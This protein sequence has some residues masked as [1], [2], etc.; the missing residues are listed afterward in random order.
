LAV[1]IGG[2]LIGL[3]AALLL[4][5]D[6]RIAGSSGILGGLIPLIKYQGLGAAKKSCIHCDHRLL[7]DHIKN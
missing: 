2:A 7:L 5:L 6:G 4:A 3:A 1:L